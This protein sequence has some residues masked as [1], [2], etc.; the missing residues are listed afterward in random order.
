ML[1]KLFLCCGIGAS[2][3]V[4]WSRAAGEVDMDSRCPRSALLEMMASAADYNEVGDVAALEL[5]VLRL[6]N[7]RQKLIVR[8]VEG[9][10]RLA[11][12]RGVK[13]ARRTDS[14]IESMMGG[15]FT[16]LPPP[17]KASLHPAFPQSQQATDAALRNGSESSSRVSD[18][19]SSVPEVRWTTVYGSAGNL[20]AGVTDGSSVWY[21]RT[22]DALPSGVRIESIR[23]DPAG[24]RVGQNGKEWQM[25]GPG[26]REVGGVSSGSVG[27][28]R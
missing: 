18:R 13:R 19:E 6:C 14:A 21:V 28:R 11:E 15:S 22:G 25:P 12:L 5:E 10:E 16:G 4:S 1:A 17:R 2:T 26:T 3:L 8:V 20:V 23:D 24:V 27:K 9:E 7:E